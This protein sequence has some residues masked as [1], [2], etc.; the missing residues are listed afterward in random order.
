MT[1]EAT[2]PKEH[3]NITDWITF[4]IT[5]PLVILDK[6]DKDRLLHHPE[7]AL[8]LL[9]CECAEVRTSGWQSQ[10]GCVTGYACIPSDKAAEFLAM[11]GS[12][13]I[14]IQNLKKDVVSYPSVVWEA[15]LLEES[16]V[17]YFQRVQKAGKD[18]KV[19]LAFRQGGGSWLGLVK[20][21]DSSMPH[22]WSIFGIPW[23][24]GPRSVHQLLV[25]NGWELVG[26][27]KPPAQARKPWGFQ[28]KHSKKFGRDLHLQGLG[29]KWRE[30]HQ[31]QK[32]DQ[33]SQVGRHRHKAHWG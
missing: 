29:W 5:S 31:Y 28:G 8:R 27:P 19:P 15:P 13:G 2:A 18:Q 24:W 3:S 9:G 14:F 1:I 11:S 32:M 33:T 22:S 20:K 21:S 4:R 17:Q 30:D 26:L 6:K 12:G 25:E 23:S 7:F 16:E 10:H